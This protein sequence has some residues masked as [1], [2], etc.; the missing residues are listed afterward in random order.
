MPTPGRDAPLPDLSRLVTLQGFNLT[1]VND[2]LHIDARATAINPVPDYVDWIVPPLPFTV[3]LPSEDGSTPIPLAAVHSAP[4]SLAVRPNLTIALAGRLLALPQEGAGGAALNGF[5]QRYLSGRPSNVSISSPLA[6]NITLPSV[7]PAPIPPPRVL[8]ELALQDM[9]AKPARGG[10][11]VVS[12]RVTAHVVLPR[13]MRFALAVPRVL[14]DVLVFDGP[15][16]PEAAGNL[17]MRALPAFPHG[18]HRDAG[19]GRGGG[20]D[21]DGDAPPA[22]PL[23][24]PLPEGAFAHIRPEDWLPALSVPM[25]PDDEAAD[26]S[27]VAV[28]AQI[29]DVPLAILPGREHLA[30]A[31]LGKVSS[32]PALPC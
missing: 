17:T 8:R 25:P 12:G 23:P 18:P 29:V 22:P 2:T 27:A 5:L 11:F 24:D 15:V 26:G 32:R 13:G 14:P 4:L 30:R 3:G 6:P 16:P 10:G 20:G 7:F 9:R 1:T 19:R 21:G 28:S 31:F